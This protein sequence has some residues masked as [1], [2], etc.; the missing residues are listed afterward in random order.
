M[1]FA[2]NRNLAAIGIFCFAVLLLT[3]LDYLIN[4]VLYS[5]GLS[6]SELW[7]QEYGIIYSLAYQLVIFTL[8]LYTRNLKLFVLFQ[9]FVLTSTQDLVYF[10]LWE[11]SFPASDWVW[12]NQY[13]LFGFWNTATQIL[14]SLGSLSIILILFHLARIPVWMRTNPIYLFGK[15]VKRLQ[16]SLHRS[17]Q[18]V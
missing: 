11:S 18:S 16:K 6:Y 8:L 17:K 7:H 1:F 14:L 12:M 9:A 5:F 15:N 13:S 10:A 3:R 4:N 2:F